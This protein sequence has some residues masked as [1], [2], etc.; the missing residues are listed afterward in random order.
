MPAPLDAAALGRLRAQARRLSRRPEEAEDLLQDVLL[1]AVVRQRYEPAWLAGVMVRRAAFV[2][3]T[4]A[5]RRH[6]ETAAAAPAD[7][8]AAPAEAL[9]AGPAALAAAALLRRLPAG[10]RRLAA[11]AA[12]GLGAPALRWL[13][14]IGPAALR[15]RQCAL[16]RR[17]SGWNAAERALW[18]KLPELAVWRRDPRLAAGPLRRALRAAQRF[19]PALG[20]HDPDGH[21]LLVASAPHAA[22]PA[23]N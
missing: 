5:R 10:Q 22:P 21:P 2:A 11:L 20:A 3:R 12:H 15:Q 18:A 9:E 7:A 17:V 23:G 13:L 1:A 8:A 19:V 16:R 4:A 6:R 14:G